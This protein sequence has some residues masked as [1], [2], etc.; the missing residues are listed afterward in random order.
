MRGPLADFTPSS[1]A[2]EGRPCAGRG[3][4]HAVVSDIRACCHSGNSYP[5]P[6]APRRY[7]VVYD[8]PG[9]EVR[10]EHAHRTL[11]QLL[12]CLKGSLSSCWTMGQPRRGPAE[13]PT[14]RPVRAPRSGRRSTVTRTTPFSSSWLRTSTRRPTTS[15]ATTTSSR[16]SG[17]E[18]ERR[19]RGGAQDAVT[20][21]SVVVPVYQNAASL[22]DLAARMRAMAE[23]CA[24][25]EFEFVFV[26]DGSRD[27]SLAVLRQLSREDPRVRVLKLSRNFGSNAADARRLAAAAATPW[28]PSRRTSR[29]RRS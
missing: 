22:P 25:T 27:D 15:A 16:P 11:H 13:R 24:P 26:E 1:A 9:K 28:S 19:R 3:C 17:A 7:F 18:A 20:L 14:S 6:F 10:G 21:I 29:T 23:A 12:V 5:L 2:T 8:V 4:G